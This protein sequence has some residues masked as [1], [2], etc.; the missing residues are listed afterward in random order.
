MELVQNFGSDNIST[1][2]IVEAYKT[3]VRQPSDTGVD[4]LKQ[5]VLQALDGQKYAFESAAMHNA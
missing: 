5:A 3:F 1:C 4:D 2:Q